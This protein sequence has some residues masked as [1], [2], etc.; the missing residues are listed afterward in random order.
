MPSDSSPELERLESGPGAKLYWIV[1]CAL[2][3]G[4]LVTLYSFIALI[5]AD[6]Y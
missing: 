4:A 3:I 6:D 5:G 2:S 1:L